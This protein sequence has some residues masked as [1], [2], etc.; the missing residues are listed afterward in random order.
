MEPKQ[1]EKWSDLDEYLKAAHLGTATP[2]V[3]I[4][5][6]EFR[7]LHPRPGV[8]EVKPVLYFVGKEKGLILTAT[9]QAYLQAT[10]GDEVKNCYG[11]RVTLHAVTKTVAGRQVDTIIIR[12]AEDK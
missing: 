2:T 8:E 10:F 5:R 11:Q 7:T 1:P 6:R 9:N 3:T 4:A 12:K